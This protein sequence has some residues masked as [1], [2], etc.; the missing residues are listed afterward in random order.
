MMDGL[1][2]REEGRSRLIER[3][4]S[5]LGRTLLRD[6]RRCA[7][8]IRQ[9]DGTVS[10]FLLTVQTSEV[11]IDDAGCF[12]AGARLSRRRRPARLGV[13]NVRLGALGR[14]PEVGLIAESHEDDYN[15]HDNRYRYDETPDDEYRRDS[16]QFR[17]G[18]VDFGLLPC[19]QILYVGLC[20]LQ[21]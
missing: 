6:R 2:R 4:V 15:H 8:S 3:L 20:V 16:R 7:G 14:R 11:E 12:D 19:V 10:M 21:T 1:Q 18:L 9:Y 5:L 17:S 13:G